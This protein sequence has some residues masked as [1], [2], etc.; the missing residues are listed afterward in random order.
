MAMQPQ[1]PPQSEH[2]VRPMSAGEKKVILA[3]SLG[4][5]FEWY[6]FYLYGSLAVIIG[7]KFF[8]QYDETTRNIFALLAFAAGF[9]VRPF[10]AL[11]FG[12]LGD[13]VG[14]KYTFLITILIM[15][16]STFLVGVL[17]TS[18]QIGFSAPRS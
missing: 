14:R 18:D 2:A 5:V 10:G 12:R 6:D 8:S 4:T 7:A 9:L 15:G 17:P 16:S 11:V 13:L 1:F 3:S